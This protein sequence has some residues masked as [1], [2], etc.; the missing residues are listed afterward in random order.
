MF[1]TVQDGNKVIYRLSCYLL[2][3]EQLTWRR[4][5]SVYFMLK[6]NGTSE[7]QGSATGIYKGD[8]HIR[9]QEPALYR[10]DL[11]HNYRERSLAKVK[12]GFF[13]D[14]FFLCTI[15]NTASSA[16]PQI[17]QCRRMLGSNS[18]HL[19]LRQWLSYRRSNHSAR[20]HPQLSPKFESRISTSCTHNA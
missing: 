3:F 20:S 13:G 14:F 17:P 5:S 19:R 12:G 6:R 2:S 7:G 18:G 9:G 15:F 8:L 10:V 4:R 16:A 1:A 11:P